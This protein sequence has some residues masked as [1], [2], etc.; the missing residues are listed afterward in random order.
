MLQLGA[1]FYWPEI[2]RFIQQD[3]IGAGLNAYMYAQNNPAYWVDPYGLLCIRLGGQPFLVFDQGSAEQLRMAALATGSEVATGLTGGLWRP[4]WSDPGDPWAGWSRGWGT[5]SGGAVAGILG[6]R[7]L[8]FNPKMAGVHLNHPPH[9]VFNLFGRHGFRARH[10][11][12]WIRRNWFGRGQPWKLRIPHS[13]F[14]YVRGR[15]PLPYADPVMPTVRLGPSTAQGGGKGASHG[16]AG[17]PCS[18]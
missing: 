5:V 1:R 12:I 13:G 8:G 17:D 3:P 7:A 4:D 6:A 11:D 18:G 16:N 14:Q 2:A 15:R 10:I 9:H